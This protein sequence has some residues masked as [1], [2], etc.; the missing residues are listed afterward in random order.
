MHEEGR[1]LVQ[2]VEDLGL[3]EDMTARIQQ[4]LEGLPPEVVQSI[5]Q[6]T[7]Q[8]LDGTEYEMPLDCMVSN[9]ELESGVPV[10]VDVLPEDGRPTIRIRPRA[11][12]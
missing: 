12:V 1:S 6:A 11:Q 3:E 5:R 2:M 4:I 9:D 8:M 7:L 10:D